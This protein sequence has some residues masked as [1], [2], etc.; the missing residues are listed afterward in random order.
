M[1]AYGNFVLDKGYDAAAALTKFRFVKQTA[2][3][4]EVTPVTAAT[5]VTHGV[6]QFGVTAAELLQGKGASVRLEGISE[7]EAGAAVAKGAEV[8]SDTSGRCVT[9]ATAGNRVVGV[10][11]QAASASGD[12]IAVRLA[13]PGRVL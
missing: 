4:E 1:P 2:N 9:A 8:M 7:V 11:L 5:D 6:A 10:A 3:A 13:L 12:R